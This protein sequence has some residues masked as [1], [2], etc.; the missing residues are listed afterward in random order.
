MYAGT[1]GARLAR[2]LLGLFVAS[3][4]VVNL[5]LLAIDIRVFRSG[6]RFYDLYEA[7]LNRDLLR[8]A[9]E[10]SKDGGAVAVSE[11]Y[12][13]MGRTRYSKFGVRALHL[14][15]NRPIIGVPRNGR[16]SRRPNG[17]VLAWA[18]RN[19]IEYYVFQEPSVPWRVWHF[20]LPVKLYERLSHT[21]FEGYTGG[22]LLFV[23]RG[24]RWEQ[25]PVSP[26]EDAMLP[27]RVPGL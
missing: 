17:D 21:T 4:I 20:R 11:K 14:L 23:R 8:V 26:P 12:V 18:K 22:W 2:G 27:T 9:V 19:D 7:G 13:N 3:V 15:T 24:S 5:A 6:E 25:V 1:F 10:V 16:L